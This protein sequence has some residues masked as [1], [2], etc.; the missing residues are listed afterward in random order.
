M[1][2]DFSLKEML[3]VCCRILPTIQN[4]THRSRSNLNRT[5][6]IV[7]ET[8]HLL[9]LSQLFIQFFRFGLSK[10][11]LFTIIKTS[12]CAVFM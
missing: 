12:V 1:F 11:P 3:R 5:N 8:M 4:K 9:I 2:S 10:C 7:S 6:Q